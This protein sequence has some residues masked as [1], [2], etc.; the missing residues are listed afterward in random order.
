MSQLRKLRGLEDRGDPVGPPLEELERNE[1]LRLLKEG[2]KNFDPKFG[3]SPVFRPLNHEKRW[4]WHRYPR[5]WIWGVALFMTASVYAP[6]F[7]AGYT[8]R[9]RPL[10]DIEKKEAKIINKAIDK[11]VGDS[12]WGE[13]VGRAREE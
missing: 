3:G 11:R 12:W 7:Y 1:R 4:I 10:T 2:R 9:H 13:L 6:I 8:S 5:G